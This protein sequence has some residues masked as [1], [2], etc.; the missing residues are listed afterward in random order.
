[1]SARPRKLVVAA[2]IEADGR[3]LLSQRRADQSLPLCWE[4][5]GGK[6]EPGEAPEAALVRELRE[7]LGCGACVGP[8]AEVI[9]HAYDDFDLVM[10]VYRCAIVEGR[11]SAVQVADV[12]W[13]L[14]AEIPKLRL[15]PA[16]VP[17]AE[18]LARGE[19]G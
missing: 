15:P 2:L 5:P 16:D 9:F 17:F 3:F 6:V 18:R 8:I 1:V 11:P 14:P 19:L 10:L 12:R 4:F 7:E 13:F